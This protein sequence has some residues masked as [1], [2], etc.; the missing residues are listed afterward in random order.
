MVVVMVIPTQ[1]PS[2]YIIEKK[3]LNHIELMLIRWVGK[4][5]RY[6]FMHMGGMT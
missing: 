3:Y 5:I 1:H 2:I 6:N 4:L